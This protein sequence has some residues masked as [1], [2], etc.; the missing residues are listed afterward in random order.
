MP[1]MLRF[2][3]YFG[4][5]FLVVFQIGCD[6]SFDLSKLDNLNSDSKKTVDPDSSGARHLEPENGVARDVRFSPNDASVPNIIIGS[7]NI[8]SFGAAKMNKPEVVS[9]LVDVARKFDILA[10]QE[11]RDKH[12]STAQDFLN[13]LNADGSRFVAS[14][15]PLQGYRV[16]GEISGYSEQAI[17]FYDSDKI[18]MISNAFVAEDRFQVAGRAAMHRAPYVAQFRCRNLPPGQAFSFVLMNV[19]TD[20]Q[21]AHDEFESLRDIISGVYAKYPNEDDFI[22]LGDMNEKPSE[23]QKYGWMMQQY[24][25]I[26]SNWLTNTRQTKNYDN[27][28]FDAGFTREFTGNSGVLN[29]MTEYNLTINQALKVSD[30]LPVWATFS[31]RE[32][33]VTAVAQEAH[34]VRR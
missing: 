14:V 30:H 6:P 32:R 25:A 13:L 2:M 11:L 1:K 7:F 4:F 33:Q 19:H 24:S 10:V 22:L 18:E 26:P 34:P 8:Q 27:I 29:L 23:F 28:T 16:N 12:G 9:V 3:P 20:P 15:G 17:F 21:D 31:T 5:L